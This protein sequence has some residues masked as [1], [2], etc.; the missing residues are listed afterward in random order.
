MLPPGD[1]SVNMKKSYRSK[2]D[3][4]VLT[5]KKSCAENFDAASQMCLQIFRRCNVQKFGASGVRH[6]L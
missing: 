2:N 6:Q 3:A 4:P 1:I 5:I